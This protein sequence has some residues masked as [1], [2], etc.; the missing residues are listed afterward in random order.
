MNE[1]TLTIESLGARGDGLARHEGA[2]IIVAG[3]L[4]GEVVRVMPEGEAASLLEIVTPAPERQASICQYFGTC[5][6]CAVQHYSPHSIAIWKADRV[7]LALRRAGIEADIAATI[8]AHGLGRRRVTLHIRYPEAGGV[9]AGFMRG[10]SHALVDLDACPLLV[11][12]LKSAPDIARE[13]GHILRGLKKPLDLQVTATP[14]G[15]D[16]D[17]RGSGR[18]PEALRLKLIEFA[19]KADLARLSVHGERIMEARVPGLQIGNPQQTMFLP[20]GSFLQATQAAEDVLCAFA[21]DALSGA[22]QVAD[23]FCGL[24][25]FALRLSRKMKVTAYDS[26]KGAIEALQRSIRANPGGK[27]IIAEARD[28]YRRPLVGPEI[29]PFDAVLLDPPRQGAE[30]QMRELGKSKIAR[31]ASISCDPESFARDAAILIAAGF[32]MGI[33][34]PVDQFRFSPHIEMTA[35]F[36]R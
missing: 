16:C 24:G 20:T 17:L 31:V 26:D 21:L 10:K 19:T 7:A 13:L 35:V 11:P 22:K 6:G 12:S 2:R 3:A 23:L 36:T 27:P 18:L 28:L 34:T 1:I 32:K 8:D 15:L 29:K 5:G 14:Q 25:P 9:E 33:V 4:P 30:A